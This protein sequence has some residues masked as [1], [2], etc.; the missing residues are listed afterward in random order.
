VDE[1]RG[2]CFLDDQ[3]I[4]KTTRNYQI[5]SEEEKERVKVKEKS[6][7]ERKKKERLI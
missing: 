1:E 5:M 7:K 4:S 6:N 2:C 3:L